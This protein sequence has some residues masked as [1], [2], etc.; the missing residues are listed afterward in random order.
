MLS[1]G[2]SNGIFRSKRINTPALSGTKTSNTAKSKLIDVENSVRANDLSVKF[3]FAQVMKFTVLL[4]VIATPLGN[5]VEP[6]V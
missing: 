1:H 2:R 6:E 4:C 5:P 3:A